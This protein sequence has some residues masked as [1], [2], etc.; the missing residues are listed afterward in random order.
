MN[1]MTEIEENKWE[2]FFGPVSNCF[3]LLGNLASDIATVVIRVRRKRPWPKCQ[4]QNVLVILPLLQ[5]SLRLKC[6]P[7]KCL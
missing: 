2:L 6:H 1:G 4:C 3:F 7:H 5:N